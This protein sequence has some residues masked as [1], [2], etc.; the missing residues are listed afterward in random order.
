MAGESKLQKK[1]RRSAKYYGVIARKVNS[2]GERGWPDL[3]LIFPVN[4]ETVFVEMKNPNEKG[5]L[6]PLQKRVHEKIRKQGAT[7][8]VCL[9]FTHFIKILECH[10]GKIK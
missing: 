5:G 2:D 4:G 10:L 1:C 6:S 8:Y 3:E 9:S 7:V